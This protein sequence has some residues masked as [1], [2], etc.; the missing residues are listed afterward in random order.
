MVISYLLT[1]CR[2]MSEKDYRATF[3]ALVLYAERMKLAS[4][5]AK[6]EQEVRA[7][8]ERAGASYSLIYSRTPCDDPRLDLL[9]SQ[10]R[11]WRKAMK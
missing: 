3:A 11:D 10:L 4:T 9:E 6:A 8:A 5:R 1:T 7:I 2:R